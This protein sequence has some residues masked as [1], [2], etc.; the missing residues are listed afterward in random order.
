MNIPDEAVEAAYLSVF[1]YLDQME[2]EARD[3]LWLALK[4]AAPILMRQA[5][6][7]G[8]DAHSQW[9]GPTQNPYT[10]KASE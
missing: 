2:D 3:I 8:W 10:R 7:E 5:W 1:P 6:D 4:D 9:P